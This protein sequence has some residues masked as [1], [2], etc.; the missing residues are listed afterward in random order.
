MNKLTKEVKQL[1]KKHGSETQCEKYKRKAN[2]LIAEIHAVKKIKEDDISKFGVTNDRDLTE[3]LQ[4]QSVSD[5][6]RIMARIVHYKT[7]YKKL[8][9]FKEKFPECKRYLTEE[10]KKNVKLKNKKKTKNVAKEV[11]PQN[12]DKSL[13]KRKTLVDET[14]ENV[15]HGCEDAERKIPE[16]AAMRNTSRKRKNSLSMALQTN[17]VTEEEKDDTHVETKKKVIEVADKQP[18]MN[19]IYSVTKEATVKKFTELLEEEDSNED[20]TSVEDRGYPA[21]SAV[22]EEKVVDDFF[23]TGDNQEKYKVHASAVTS[24]TKPDESKPLPSSNRFTRESAK[25]K[26]EE[27]FGKPQRHNKLKHKSNVKNDSWNKEYLEKET[28]RTGRRE[29][30]KSNE[31]RNNNNVKNVEKDLH[32]SWLA[33]KKQQEV[34]SQGFQGRKIVFNDD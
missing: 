21:D 31:S 23:I 26:T 19:K 15:Q 5:S 22:M 20:M 34:M 1:Q 8:I 33:K 27:R 4:D 3:I 29:F 30:K 17:K 12:Q 16:S 25:Y 28:S 9:Q 24:S 7:L 32:P 10:R 13:K 2:K 11:N 18:G 6:D 14:V